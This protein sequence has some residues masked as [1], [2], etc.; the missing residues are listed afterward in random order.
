MGPS[1]TPR[2]AATSHAGAGQGRSQGAAGDRCG[3]L[4][5]CGTGRGRRWR[6]GA[7]GPGPGSRG[8]GLGRAGAVVG[9]GG[10]GGQPAC[11]DRR[12]GY[13]GGRV[14]A[15]AW[16][17]GGLC[18][19]DVDPAAGGSWT[20]PVRLS[21]H[22]QFAFAPAVAVSPAGGAVVVWSA[23]GTGGPG[24]RG[25]AVM[26]AVRRSPRQQ[27]SR[28]VR[29]SRA[30]VAG[31]QARV[32][33]DGHGHA[34]AIWASG[35][36][37]PGR[38]QT[39]TLNLAG[40]RWSR[41]FLLAA[42]RQRLLDPQIAAS[43][44]GDL[45]AAWKRLTGG[46]PLGPRGVRAQIAARVRPAGSRSWLPAT[47]LGPELELPGQDSAAPEL[48]G[49]QVA[50]D[51]A[52][53]AA[54]SWQGPWRRTAVPEV[55]LRKAGRPWHKPARLATTT[56]LFP[57]VAA[58]DR[59]DLAALWEGAG[60]SVQTASRPARAPGWSTP[61]TLF[62]GKP[63]HRL[64]PAAGVRP[65]RGNR[66]SLGREHDPGRRAAQ[67][68]RG[69]VTAGA[70]GLRRARAA[71]IRPTGP[72]H[73]GVAAAG[74]PPSRNSRA[75]RPVQPGPGEA[76]LNGPGHRPRGCPPGHGSGMTC[77]SWRA[78]VTSFPARSRS[79]DQLACLQEQAASARCR[80]RRHTGSADVP[81]HP[82]GL[83]PHLC[84]GHP[85]SQTWTGT[86]PLGL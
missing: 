22:G 15:A 17:R 42:A 71:G 81:S 57:S 30:G 60:G 41:P 84:A 44:R 2:T 74:P 75:G 39:A 56:G 82:Q 19:D 85:W 43:A 58:D 49:P 20:P 16:R 33:M 28:P 10:P 53:D 31:E 35:G 52:G 77:S 55:A 14:G 29:L 48:P 8:R 11:H 7:R 40:G 68:G 6:R 36:N 32:A 50:I 73:R 34:T 21:A 70:A 9:A 1:P 37:G 4:P 3:R 76:G 26:A 18:R 69:L 72:G 54:V 38:I 65:G 62:R 13:R 5:G 61:R 80:L 24:L 79:A 66:R 47:A 64:V 23:A 51:A 86:A 59:G 78:A 83:S 63:G 12:R 27:W 25:Q 46:A 45:V 67:P